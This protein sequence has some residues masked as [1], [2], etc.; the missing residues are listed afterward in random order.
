MVSNSS[1]GHVGEHDIPLELRHLKRWLDARDDRLEE[2]REDILGV[3]ELRSLEVARISGDVGEQEAAF[4]GR[5][6]VRGHGF[7]PYPR[8]WCR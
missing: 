3:F 2:I 6:E 5:G 1:G 8:V 4:L 7:E